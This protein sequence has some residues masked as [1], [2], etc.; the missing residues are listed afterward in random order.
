M[1][2]RRKM[3]PFH[4]VRRAAPSAASNSDLAPKAMNNRPTTRV[5]TTPWVRKNRRTA[6]SPAA[7]ISVASAARKLAS[8]AS[9]SCGASPRRISP[10]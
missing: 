4:A 2:S 8:A 7:K 6:G 1:K 5:T 10:K 3:A 9:Y